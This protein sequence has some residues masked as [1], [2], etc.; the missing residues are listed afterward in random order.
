MNAAVPDPRRARRL[1]LFLAGLS[2]VLAAGGALWFSRT[3]VRMRTDPGLSWRTP[4]VL[5]RM[6][7][8]GEEAER[9]G[10]RGAA[11]AAYRFVLRVGAGGEPAYEPYIAA[12][13][14]ALARLGADSGPSP[15]PSDRVRA[16]PDTLPGRGR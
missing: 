5:D 14:R 12:A 8:R 16:A 7:A 11:I 2:L 4:E 13:R 1:A 10:D 15:A 9:A 6:L 3:Q